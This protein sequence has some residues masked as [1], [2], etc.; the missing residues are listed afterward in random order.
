MPHRRKKRDKN[1]L[2]R[3]AGWRRLPGG[4]FLMA[5]AGDGMDLAVYKGNDGTWWYALVG[6]GTD[7]VV[8]EGGGF[9]SASRASKAARV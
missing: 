2:T 6:H 4:I 3:Y 1:D 5:G 8:R 9:P 7:N